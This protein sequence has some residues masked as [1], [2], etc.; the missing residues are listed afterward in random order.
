MDIL[1]NEYE[2]T[3][4]FEVE[5]AERREADGFISY[6]TSDLRGVEVT[7]SFSE[8]EGSFQFRLD[9]A[10]GTVVVISSEQLSSVRIV[11]DKTGEYLEIIASA[12]NTRME[13]RLWVKPAIR[14]TQS[15]LR[16]S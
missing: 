9:L 10:S 1:P 4:F 16:A 7:A 2:L 14:F 12:P 8:T 5:P 15:L 11:R 3:A 6:T 13:S